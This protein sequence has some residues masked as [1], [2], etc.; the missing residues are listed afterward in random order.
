MEYWF[1]SKNSG[2][3]QILCWARI[4]SHTMIPGIGSMGLWVNTHGKMMLLRFISHVIDYH[5]HE[6]RMY[7]PY[8]ILQSTIWSLGWTS[9]DTIGEMNNGESLFRG[10]L[11]QVNDSNILICLEPNV[12]WFIK[13]TNKIWQLN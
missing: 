2:G 6:G 10:I 1:T 7:P 3:I 11:V 5:F 9:D 13:P 4:A 12:L 8:W